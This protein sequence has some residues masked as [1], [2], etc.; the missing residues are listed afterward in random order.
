MRPIRSAARALILEEGRLLVSKMRDERGIFYVLPGGGQ[1]P[2]ETLHEALHRE[3][4]EEVGAKI[5]VGEMLF[6]RE[7]IGKNHDFAH[8]HREFHQLEHVFRCRLLNPHEIGLG[9]ETDVRQVGVSW[10]AVE[11]IHLTR[12]L[13]E[14]LK[15]YFVD[16]D[17]RPPSLYLGDCY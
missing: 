13:P 14:V 6:V 5:E 8:R 11:N 16:G 17:F 12:F 1:N 2:G 4:A 9:H 15:P 3:C 10:L 7:Y